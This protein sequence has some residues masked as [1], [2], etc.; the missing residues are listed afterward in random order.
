MTSLG[1]SQYFVTFIDDAT[2]KLWV[3]FL[4]HKS[5]VFDLFKKWKVLVDN[6]PGLKMKCHR[7]DNAGEYCS[8]EFERYCCTDRIR[9][10]KTIPNTPQ[11]NRVAKRMN[12]TIMERSRNMRIHVGLPKQ[13]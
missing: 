8:K 13:F 9:R 3:C 12:G 1:S 11:Q 2:R 10:E 7:S 6:E 4:K 5:D